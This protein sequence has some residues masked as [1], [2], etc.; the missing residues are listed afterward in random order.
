MNVADEYE[1]LLRDIST[2]YMERIGVGIQQRKEVLVKSYWEIGDMIVRG[3]RAAKITQRYGKKL[4][5]QLSVDLT[6]R[7]GSGFGE[8][9]I[10]TIRRF[11]L[12][13][14]RSALHPFLTWAHYKT[15]LSVKDVGQRKK[16]ESRAIREQIPD[17]QL[18]PL[19]RLLN[20]IAIATERENLLL[21]RKGRLFVYKVV[22]EPQ[23]GKNAFLLDCG[24]QVKRRM[25]LSGVRQPADGDLLQCTKTEEGGY[26]F[27]R[28]TDCQPGERYCYNGTVLKVVD[29]DTLLV[30][31]DLGFDGF[32]DDRFRLRGVD[33]PELETADGQM[34]K[35]FVMQRLRTGST[36]LLLTYGCDKYG[37]YLADVYF[38]DGTQPPTVDTGRFLNREM[39]EKGVAGYWA[40][41]RWK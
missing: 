16:L 8:T 41:M 35:R 33:A 40:P 14:R 29:G 31:V 11:R 22:S 34:A 26:R 18:K 12:E 3:E 13:Y 25:Q 7:F 36:V 9:N 6:E 39:L 1:T 20:G 24:F 23:G 17:K 19:A 32:I 4:V 30:R 27:E 37:R 38:S 5:P 2:L 21:P 10:F 15:L 28:I